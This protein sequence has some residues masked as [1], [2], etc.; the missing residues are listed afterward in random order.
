M[1]SQ[2]TEGSGNELK[3]N[4]DPKTRQASK[5]IEVIHPLYNPINADN[6][7]D[8]HCDNNRH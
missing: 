1:Q 8:L 2:N 7:V 3:K 5:I 6:F 4:L